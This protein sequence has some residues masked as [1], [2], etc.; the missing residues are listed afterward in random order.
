MQW[1]TKRNIENSILKYITEN[2]NS[3][4]S[5]I[6]IG[7][8][9]NYKENNLPFVAIRLDSATHKKLELGSTILNSKDLV[10]IDL[11]CKGDGQ[12]LDLVEYLLDILREG[13]PYYAWSPNP[14]D[15]ENPIIT[16]DGWVYVSIAGDIKIDLGENVNICDK[17]RHRITIELERNKK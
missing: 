3:D 4:W 5:G 11:Y 6:N 7:L 17:F 16:V 9:F 13:F 12:R 14:A 10:I 1:R 15:K 2:I 8:S